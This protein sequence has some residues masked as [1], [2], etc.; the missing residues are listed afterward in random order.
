MKENLYQPNI[1]A[2]QLTFALQYKCYAKQTA[3]QTLS[4]MTNEI[5][6]GDGNC[7]FVS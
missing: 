3:L 6:Y 2:L 1:F 5:L 7:H 4:K